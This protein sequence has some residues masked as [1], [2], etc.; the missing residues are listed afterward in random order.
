MKGSARKWLAAVFLLAAL[1]L[2]MW[3]LVG[4]GAMGMAQAAMPSAHGGLDVR[5]E[6]TM[7]RWFAPTRLMGRASPFRALNIP[8]DLP[9]FGTNYRANTDT[10]VPNL[11]QQEPSIAINPTNVLNVV[12]GAKDERAGTNTKQDWIYTSTDGGVTWI[13][14]IFPF[15]PPASPFSSDPVVNFSDDGIVYFTAL[16][17]GGGVN[18]GIQVARSTDGGITFSTGV[19]LPGTNSNSDKEWTWIDNFPSSPFYHRIYTAW[20]DFGSGNVWRLN[21]S[22]DRGATW[23]APTTT[24]LANQFPMPVVLPNGDVIVTYRGSSG[25]GVYRRSTDGGVTF[26]S[27]LAIASI[28]SPNCPPDNSGCNIWRLSPI[29]A[30]SVN[31][32]NGTMV[33]MWADGTGGGST[34][35]YSRS[36]NNGSTWSASA[37]LSSSGI[38]GTYQVEPWVEAD[39]QGIFHSVWYD[40][41]EAP[42]TSIF[43]I[44]YSQ[45]T[46]NGATWSSAVRI[47]TASSDLRIGIPT[48]YSRAA[49]DYINV[50]AWAGNVYAAW[51][52]TRSGT[53][54]DIYVV[55]GTFGGPTAT[56]TATRTNTPTPTFTP[57]NTSTATATNTPEVLIQGHVFL[58]GRPPQPNPRQSVPIT[59]TLRLT[60]GGPDY[61]Y[62]TTTDDN[63]VFT[64]TAPAPG[65]YNFRVKNPQT[66]ANAG[67][68]SALERWKAGT[69]P[70][71]MGTLLEGDASNDNC[72]NVIDFTLAKNAFGKSEGDPGYDP[73]ADFNGDSTI[74]VTDFN[75][76]KSNFGVCGARPIRP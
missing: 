32:N 3:G 73:R 75:L 6:S 19:R 17:Y 14:Q 22:S 44:Y 39:D 8:F 70:V 52:D 5:R 16:P 31:R 10:Q 33:V 76:L 61:N 20:M 62:V 56:P 46:D 45:S 9:L 57:T 59:F 54:E 38:P 53:G 55:R 68:L 11:A 66:L 40:D 25:G 34:I 64:V 30:N 27:Q 67:T 60:S 21:Y 4:P 24:F 1:V 43:Q 7:P 26:G 29:P 51:T 69:T 49:G 12:A 72:V 28:T 63:G 37:V 58:Q 71:E 18:D 36:T 42:N 48:S 41:R 35:R 50:T 47:S 15:L 74:N 2:G 23:S 65:T 13:N